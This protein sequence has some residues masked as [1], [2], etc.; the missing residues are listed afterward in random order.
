MRRLSNLLLVITITACQNNTLSN[1]TILTTKTNPNSLKKYK[2]STTTNTTP[3]KIAIQTITVESE[4]P[5]A[6]KTQLID[7]NLSSPW[8]NNDRFKAETTLVLDLGSLNNLSQLKLKMPGNSGIKYDLS[9]SDNKTIWRTTNTNEQNLTWGLET[10]NLPANTKGRY[11]KLTF[12]NTPTK[13]IEYFIVFEVELWGSNNIVSP[14]SP[15]PSIS[16]KP[17]TSPTI[18]PPSSPS[19]GPS[20]SPGSTGP[21]RYKKPGVLKKINGVLPTT[22]SF[23]TLP[24]NLSIPLLPHTETQLL[25]CWNSN[26]YQFLNNNYAPKNYDIEYSS[27]SSNGIDGT[28]AIA[29]KSVDN[30]IRSRFDVIQAP[31]NSKYLRLKLLSKWNLAPQLKDLGVYVSSVN[32]SWDSLLVMGDSITA[33]SF[34][35]SKP[36]VYNPGSLIFSGGTGGD[37]AEMGLAKLKTAMPLIPVGSYIGIAY[38]TNDATRGVPVTVFKAKLQEM[39]TLV[40]NNGSYPILARVPWNLNGGL[41]N[42][43]KAI[44]D[45]VAENKL[46]AGPDLYTYILN[47]K[48]ALKPDKVHLMPSGETAFQRLWGEAI[49]KANNLNP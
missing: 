14:I 5:S 21:R 46:V 49:K 20:Q 22:T 8:R 39:I 18:S 33:Q 44:D 15:S 47:N 31:A 32:N 45:L 29:K 42:Y 3:S 27:D 26:G 4:S 40:L 34:D 43:L 36:T 2:L 10:K 6:P 41:P 7:Q 28:W 16:P 38:G 48:T 35:P 17:S 37:T 9:V 30:P 1:P 13:S 25:V 23:N 19:V 24:T 12:K 11:V